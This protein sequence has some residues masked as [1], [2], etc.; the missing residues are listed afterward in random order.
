MTK[1]HSHG[2]NTWADPAVVRYL[3]ADDGAPGGIHDEPDVRL[4]TTDFDIGFVGREDTAGVVIVVIDK[5]LDTDSG[6]FAVIGYLL[7]RDGDVV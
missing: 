3:I 4:D 7:M 5:S 1:S 2:E 6:S